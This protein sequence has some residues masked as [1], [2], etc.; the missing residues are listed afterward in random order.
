M[1]LAPGVAVPCTGFNPLPLVHH[2]VL[3]AREVCLCRRQDRRHR[4]SAADPAD[5]AVLAGRGCDGSW[6]S[7]R[8]AAR[9]SRR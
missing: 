7:R 3:P 6:K 2:A 5:G 9:H 4:L 1:S 8:C